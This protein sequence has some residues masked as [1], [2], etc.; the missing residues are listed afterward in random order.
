[1]SHPPQPYPQPTPYP[2]PYFQA[3]P[4]HPE[5]TTIL[6]LGALGFVFFPCGIIAWS[7]GSKAMKAIQ[8][9]GFRYSNESN[10]NLGRI[11][12]MV[13]SI[14]GMVAVGLVL[15]QIV[16]SIVFWLVTMASLATM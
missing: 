9:G 12:G 7:M 8:A 14:I 1:M 2:R 5:A 3:L 10:V 13:T 4:E 6:V 16:G 15:V 11:L